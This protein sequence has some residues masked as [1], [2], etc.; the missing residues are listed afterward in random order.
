MYN[1]RRHTVNAVKPS[2][3]NQGA[4]RHGVSFISTGAMAWPAWS[5]GRLP[6]SPEGF[7][8]VPWAHLV[9]NLPQLQRKLK[10]ALPCIGLDGIGAGLWEVGWAGMD[11]IHAY[12]I[13]TELIPALQ[14]LHG[15]EVVERF[16]I[17]PSGNLLNVDV[18]QMEDVDLIIA[19]PPC[20]PWSSIG[21][22][23][24]LHDE[25]TRVFYAVHNM[26]KNQYRRMLK[27]FIVEMV[28]GMAHERARG[29]STGLGDTNA[30]RMWL[31]EL[32]ED[33]PGFR[34]Y[35]VGTCKALIMCHSTACDC[36]LWEFELK[37]WA[38]DC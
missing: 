27:A 36:T 30:H 12:D 31:H 28:A 4:T 6:V 29:S 3:L 18:E 15:R 10:T 13:D 35:I 32:K 19:G 5:A 2:R 22:R 37:F 8:V 33:L 14:A 9:P 38:T 25:R 21:L 1:I 34:N 7:P 26:L 24:G 23:R 20:P 17:G 11:I 16:N